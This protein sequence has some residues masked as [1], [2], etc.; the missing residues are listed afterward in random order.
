MTPFFCPE[1]PLAFNNYGIKIWWTPSASFC[2]LIFYSIMIRRLKTWP[3]LEGKKAEREWFAQDDS[4]LQ[5]CRQKIWQRKTAWGERNAVFSWLPW[6]HSQWPGPP[7]RSFLWEM[8][9]GTC[10]WSREEEQGGSESNAEICYR[11]PLMRVLSLQRLMEYNW[12]SA[13]GHS[14]AQLHCSRWSHRHS[15]HTH[16]TSVAK[17]KANQF[18]T[19][20]HG[21]TEA[22]N[23]PSG[24]QVGDWPV[25][26]CWHLLSTIGCRS[27]WSKKWGS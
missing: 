5:L 4:S 1:Q 24:S 3:G 10:S 2:L 27:I 14:A 21:V 17:L 7:S 19:D 12:I 16:T 11:G 26:D 13:W 15:T 9:I 22:R 18:L 20:H 6:E 25:E 23:I 8:S